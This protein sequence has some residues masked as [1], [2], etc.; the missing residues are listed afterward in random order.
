MSKVR[1]RSQE[2]PMPKGRH[3]R[4]TT[5]RLKS[6]VAAR[7]SYPMTEVRGRCQEEL[8]CVVAETARLQQR[9]SS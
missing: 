4:G 5:P 7:K 6:E 9:R 8:A 3:P 2:D 1:D